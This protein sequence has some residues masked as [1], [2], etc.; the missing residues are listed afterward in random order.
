MARS[1]A[2]TPR[3]QSS[4][5]KTARRPAC[6]LRFPRGGP[7]GAGSGCAPLPPPRRRGGPSSMAEVRTAA[8]PVA[9]AG[10]SGEEVRVAEERLVEDREVG[11]ER[12][13]EA[14]GVVVEPRH[15]PPERRCLLLV[16]HADVLA[17]EPAGDRDEERSTPL[18]TWH[19]HRPPPVPR[20]HRVRDEHVGLGAHGVQPGLLR[21]HVRRRAVG[22]RVDPQGEPSPVVGVQAER[23]VVGV[24]HERK[25]PD[26]EAEGSRSRDRHATEGLDLALGVEAGIGRRVLDGCHDHS[27]PRA[28]VLR[29]RNGS[30]RAWPTARGS[31]GAGARRRPRRPRGR[32]W[33]A[34]FVVIMDP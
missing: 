25:A 23:R 20:G 14:F 31:G 27:E 7:R 33:G 10:P 29:P 1:R 13:R 8:S 30:T 2:G 16:A 34:D 15:G 11:A 17:L 22:V 32:G 12:E 9:Q 4:T 18:G 6:H 26:A 21:Q 28:R 3:P 19:L 24:E 5:S